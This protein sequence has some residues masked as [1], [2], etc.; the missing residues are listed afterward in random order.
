MIEFGHG[1]VCQLFQGAT[2]ALEDEQLGFDVRYFG[3]NSCFT[4][5][6]VIELFLAARATK[7]IR[8]APGLSNTVT[9]HPS[10]VANL[11]ASIQVASGGRAICGIGKGDSA[12]GVIGRGPQ[13]HDEFVEKATM[14]RNY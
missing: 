2:L 4:P 11:I 8:L 12:M 1:T 10:V 3:D 9:K 14:L 6:P 5:D 13:K 7:T